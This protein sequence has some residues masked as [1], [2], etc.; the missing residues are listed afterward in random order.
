MLA[1]KSE[2]DGGINS[3]DLCEV[4]S[5]ITK[6]ILRADQG[7]LVRIERTYI[8]E[9]KVLMIC[10]DET[11][12]EWAKHVVVV[13]IPSLVDHQ[14]YDGKGPKDLPPAKIF[15]IGLPKDEDL[16]ISDILTLVFRCDEKSVPQIWK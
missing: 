10:E 1:V 2:G 3:K 5:A 12:L 14:G 13:I 16:S 9:D 15:G 7:F 8:F 11:T 6:M 4:Q